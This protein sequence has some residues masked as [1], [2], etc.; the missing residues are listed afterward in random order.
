MAQLRMMHQAGRPGQV[1]PGFPQTMRQ[2]QQFYAPLGHPNAQTQRG[3]F[4]PGL[5]PMQMQRPPG[6]PFSQAIPMP[7]SSPQNSPGGVPPNA[8]QHGQHSQGQQ[9]QSDSKDQN[10]PLFMLK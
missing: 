5:S 3:H 6:M 9:R 1:P 2:M 10:D 8:G 4:Q 7:A